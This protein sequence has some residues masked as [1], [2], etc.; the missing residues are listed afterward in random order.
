VLSPEEAFVADLTERHGEALLHLEARPGRDGRQTLLAV[1]D[2]DA[3]VLAAES[4]RCA[5]LAEIAVEVMDKDTWLAM[6]R[7]AARGLISFT[8][9]AR[10]LHRSPALADDAAEEDGGLAAAGSGAAEAIARADRAIGVARLLG[11]GG[12]AA[13]AAAA[14]AK[15]PRHIAAALLASRGEAVAVEAGASDAEVRRLVDTGALC[16]DAHDVLGAQGAGEPDADSIVRL[17]ASASRIL[18]DARR[19]EPRLMAA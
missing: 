18:A 4:A 1:L 5:A 13:E 19:N 15:A 3:R 11:Q 9:E 6:R 7:L 14:L 10:T 16:V 12:F 2:A 17:I 8:E